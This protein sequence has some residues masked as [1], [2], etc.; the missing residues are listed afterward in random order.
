MKLSLAAY[1]AGALSQG[2]KAPPEVANEREFEKGIEARK[3]DGG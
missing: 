2:R 1:T 3:E